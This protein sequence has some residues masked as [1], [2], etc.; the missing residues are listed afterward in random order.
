[1]S[2]NETSY[3]EKGIQSISKTF[4]LINT[5]GLY[6]KRVSKDAGWGKN[7]LNNVSEVTSLDNADIFHTH[8]RKSISYIA[9]MKQ[10]FIEIPAYE[11]RKVYLGAY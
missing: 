8:E 2:E 11:V 1:M 10:G 5:K 7:D 3:D 9:A 6:A 4:V